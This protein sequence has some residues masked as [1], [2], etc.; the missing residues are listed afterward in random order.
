MA[1]WLPSPDDDFLRALA[2]KFQLHTNSTQNEGFTI[3]TIND[4]GAVF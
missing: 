4:M 3:M 2:F 1:L